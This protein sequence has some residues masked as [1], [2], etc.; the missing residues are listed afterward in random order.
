MLA[1]GDARA[2]AQAWNAA[3]FNARSLAD[4]LKAL[5][6]AA[7]RDSRDVVITAPDIAEN[8]AAVQVSLRSAIPR[9]D[10]AALLIE[11][12]PNPLAGAFWFLEAGEPE[13]S[14][15]VKMSQG[16]DLVV[17]VRAEGRFFVARHEVTVT[18]GGCGG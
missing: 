11:R 15:R 5:G 13:A 2:Q 14:V 9:T 1:S 4:A 18:L 8:G 16:S 17:L 6:A 10:F 3:A 7:P 12:N